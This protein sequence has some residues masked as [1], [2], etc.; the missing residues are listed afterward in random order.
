[1]QGRDRGPLRVP[2]ESGEGRL[3]EPWETRGQVFSD[4]KDETKSTIL[5]GM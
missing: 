1:M 3:G 2:T 4:R 5:E